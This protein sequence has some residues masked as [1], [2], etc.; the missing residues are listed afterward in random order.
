MKMNLKIIKGADMKIRILN[1]LIVLGLGLLASSFVACESDNGSGP[2]ADTVD[3]ALAEG[4]VV[5]MMTPED[6][7]IVQAGSTVEVKWKADAD[8]F[9]GFMVK[10]SPDAGESWEIV[11]TESLHTDAVGEGCL[12]YDWE[13]SEELLI[14]GG[15]NDDVM[16]RVQDYSDADL[17]ATS[18]GITV[19]PSP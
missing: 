8:Q 13:V 15:S 17:R 11:V 12:T 7:A 14:E 19:E 4:E 5:A 18:E 16:V 3:C 10:V 2:D 1:S 9:T 6:G